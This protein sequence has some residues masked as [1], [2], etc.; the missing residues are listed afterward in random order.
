MAR[1]PHGAWDERDPPGRP[2]P[3]WPLSATACG[4]QPS[5]AG[6]PRPRHG[7]GVDGPGAGAAGPHGGGGQRQGQAQRRL[8]HGPL[9][10]PPGGEAADRG[11]VVPHFLGSAEGMEVWAGGRAARRLS[12]GCLRAARR[13]ARARGA[14]RPHEG[15]PHHAVCV[16]PPAQ[17]DPPPLRRT[18]SNPSAM[19]T[20][21]AAAG[22]STAAPALRSM[23]GQACGPLPG[24]PSGAGGEGLELTF[25][26]ALPPEPRRAPPRAEPG[27]RGREGEAAW[28]G[29][30]PTGGPGPGAG[31]GPSAAA[32]AVIER[33]L[34][35]QEAR[36]QGELRRVHMLQELLRQRQRKLAGRR[37][38]DTP[39]PSAAAIGSGGGAGE[40]RASDPGPAGGG[41]ELAGRGDPQRSGQHSGAQGSGGGGGAGVGPEASLSEGQSVSQLG[42]AAGPGRG[43]SSGTAGAAA[44]VGGGY[45]SS[46]ATA[47]K[48]EPG[49][50]MQW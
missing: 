19:A 21:A 50:G 6:G 14:M 45:G 38:S 49:D 13:R 10:G 24:T 1:S 30:T 43:G 31:A 33:K 12:Q 41:P 32:L 47:I 42:G 23:A 28:G 16:A 3:S 36:L 27:P 22:P 34:A 26:G 35:A 15:L 39:G 44:A 9:P 25:A 5:G 4:G 46:T 17:V 11:G 20:A 2:G 18:N 29:R 8:S 48:V 40:R 37:E 7:P